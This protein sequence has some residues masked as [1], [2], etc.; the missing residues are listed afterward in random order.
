MCS[1]KNNDVQE[2]ALSAVANLL[3]SNTQRLFFV[4]NQQRV[5]ILS[6]WTAKFCSRAE[7]ASWVIGSQMTVTFEKILAA[8]VNLSVEDGSHAALFQVRALSYL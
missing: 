4:K 3:T 7:K 2:A 5:K 8:M 1:H 6:I